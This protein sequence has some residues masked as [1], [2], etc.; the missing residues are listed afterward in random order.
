MADERIKYDEEMVGHSHPSKDDTLNRITLIEHGTDG[1]HLPSYASL[2]EYTPEGNITDI[3]TAGTFVKWAHS[4]AGLVTGAPYI[5]SS[6]ANDNITIGADGPG[7]YNIFASASIEGQEGMSVTIA[8]FID[9]VRE[10]KLTRMVRLGSAHEHFP[11]SVDLKIGVLNSGDVTTLQSKDATYYD[12]QEV[13]E[14]TGALIDL[15]FNDVEA[16]L[17]IDFAGRYDGTA[18]HEVECQI[19]DADTGAGEVQNGG[20]AYTC[21][22]SHTSG[23]LADEPGVGAVWESFWE[24]KGAVTTEPAWL[25]ATAYIDAFDEVRSAIKDLPHSA[26]VDYTRRWIIP[27]THADRKKYSDGDSV[28][29]VRFIH[30]SGGNTGHQHLHDTVSLQDDHAGASI[31][32]DDLIALTATKEIDLRF[33]TNIDSSS[34]L[35]TSVNLNA[36][37]KK[38]G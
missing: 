18:A 22:R 33:A 35:T 24:L 25:T 23:D 9:G 30:N 8:V 1:T 29:R 14:P 31:T 5:T 6:V 38:I 10:D 19:Y 15:T 17:I 12:V 16:P 34:I 11:D 27:G 13:A 2:Y 32:M 3:V 21:I 20:N 28:C 36:K 7:D 4:V 26:G 37:R